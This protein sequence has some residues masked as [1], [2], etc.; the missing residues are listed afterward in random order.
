MNLFLCSFFVAK[1][2]PFYGMRLS[3]HRLTLHESHWLNSIH[4]MCARR[5]GKSIEKGM[6]YKLTSSL[7]KQETRVVFDHVMSS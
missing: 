2:T 6:C 7:L 4:N 1:G 5:V 3:T